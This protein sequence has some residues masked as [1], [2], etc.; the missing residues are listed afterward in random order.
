MTSADLD[1]R[2]FLLRPVNTEHGC[3][4]RDRSPWTR[5]PL[6]MSVV[7][8]IQ[9]AVGTPFAGDRDDQL[10]RLQGLDGLAV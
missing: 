5:Q 6:C 8:V 4:V 1:L 3:H 2:M 9:R 7:T 10:R